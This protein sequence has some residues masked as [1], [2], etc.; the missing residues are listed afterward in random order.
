MNLLC[1]PPLPSH[2]LLTPVAKPLLTCKSLY[3]LATSTDAP[4][5]F[6]LSVFHSSSHVLNL[7]KDFHKSYSK[8]FHKESKKKKKTVT[9]QIE[10]H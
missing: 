6:C 3:P 8:M 5:D 10:C 2:T 1:I 9:V 4:I 7:T